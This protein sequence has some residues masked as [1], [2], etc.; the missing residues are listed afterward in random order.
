MNKSVLK[1]QKF[2]KPQVYFCLNNGKKICDA[3]LVCVSIGKGSCRRKTPATL[4]TEC[5]TW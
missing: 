5:L 1:S 4:D 2:G 3:C